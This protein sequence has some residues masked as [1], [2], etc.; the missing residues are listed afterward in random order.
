MNAL[1]SD[2]EF[3]TSWASC[4]IAALPAMT[5]YGLTERSC[6]GRRH[7]VVPVRGGRGDRDPHEHHGRGKAVADPQR[8]RPSACRASATCGSDP[9]P[10]GGRT[11][12]ATCGATRL[13]GWLHRAGQAERP[14]PARDWTAPA[15]TTSV[16]CGRAAAATVRGRQD[17]ADVYLTAE[18]ERRRG[19]SNGERSFRRSSAG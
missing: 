13:G 8:A 12:T 1:E 11:S 18:E 7:R 4:W 2:P 9:N 17:A 10:L 5:C 19:I 14:R 6:T 3:V 15:A 16:G